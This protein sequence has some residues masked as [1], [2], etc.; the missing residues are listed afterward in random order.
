MA[1]L[2][3]E[4][5]GPVPLTPAKQTGKGADTVPEITGSTSGE[6]HLHFDSYDRYDT[7]DSKALDLLCL[8]IDQF[9]VKY[10]SIYSGNNMRGLK[11]RAST[12]NKSFSR[13][14]GNN[15]KRRQ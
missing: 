2:E 6:H 10:A 13:R 11:T 8:R 3:P 15:R 7:C 12:Q 9:R 14:R 4:P 1:E 5:E